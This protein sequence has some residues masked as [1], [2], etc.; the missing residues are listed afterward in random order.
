MKTRLKIVLWVTGVS[1]VVCTFAFYLLERGANENINNFGDSLWWFIVTTSTVGYGDIY[2][3]TGAGRIVAVLSILIGFYL[4]TNLVAIITDS[5]QRFVE[6]R[7]LGLVKVE[8]KD[9][10]VVCDY[11]AVADEMLR[12]IRKIE[13]LKEREVVI[14]TDLVRQQPYPDYHFVQGVPFSPEALDRASTKDAAYVLIFANFRFADPD[15]KTLHVAS[16]VLEINPQAAVLVE[17]IDPESELLGLA[18]G[19]IVAMDSRRL[20]EQVLQREPLDPREWLP[21]VDGVVGSP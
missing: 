15:L 14:V 13:G 1:L 7:R 19:N 9:H 4:F 11:T 8:C 5:V 21:S 10:I 2:P 18:Q 16:R 20:I 12:S 3:A 17:M 6:R